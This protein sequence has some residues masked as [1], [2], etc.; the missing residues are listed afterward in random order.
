MARTKQSSCKTAATTT[1]YSKAARKRLAGMKPPRPN[2][3]LPHGGQSKAANAGPSRA[4]TPRPGVEDVEVNEVTGRPIRKSAGRRDL[5]LMGYLDSTAWVDSS[6]DGEDSVEGAGR[7][8]SSKRRRSLSSV[9]IERQRRARGDLSPSP[10]ALSDYAGTPG[11]TPSP[12]PGSRSTARAKSTRPVQ[13]VQLTF[14]VPR[15]HHGPFVVHLDLPHVLSDEPEATTNAAPGKPST[16]PP[17]DKA[18]KPQRNDSGR[19]LGFLNLPAELRNAIYRL[20]FT[21]KKTINFHMRENLCHSAAL[22]STCKQISREGSTVLYG[23]NRFHFERVAWTRGQFY[24][25]VWREIGYKDMERFLVTIG[26]RNLSQ[27]TSLILILEDARPITSK[28]LTHAER[29]YVRDPHLRHCLRLLGRYGNLKRLCLGVNG[30]QHFTRYHQQFVD[31]LVQI[32]TLDELRFLGGVTDYKISADDKQWLKSEMEWG[33]GVVRGSGN[34][35][36]HGHGNA[37]GGE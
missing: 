1:G 37:S 33:V 18:K 22:L 27:I 6:S 35:G 26:P 14:A 32:N 2:K 9:E 21:S 12:P 36:G 10:A 23:E 17:L 11:R 28:E 15:G 19:R 24:E 29:Q 4:D 31:V 7:G 8:R 25:N 16:N 3:P 13:P 34:G 20:V 30:R 5:A